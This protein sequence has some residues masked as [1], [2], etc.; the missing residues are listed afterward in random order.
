M[1]LSTRRVKSVL[2]VFA[3]LVVLMVSIASPAMA[4]HNNDGWW[5][6]CEWVAVSW[7]WFPVWWGWDWDWNWVLVCDVDDDWWN[8]HNDNRHH[9]DWRNNPWW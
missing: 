4:N 3:M 5:D 2:V 1:R 7:Y 8:H 9:N 6:D